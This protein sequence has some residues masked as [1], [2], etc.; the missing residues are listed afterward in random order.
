[1]SDAS[2]S[3]GLVVLPITAGPLIFT[4]ETLPTLNF[5]SGSLVS[6][7]TG[8]EQTQKLPVSGSLGKGV[9]DSDHRNHCLRMSTLGLPAAL[10]IHHS[11][12][13]SYAS[14]LLSAFPTSR[15]W[16]LLRP[17]TALS[18]GSSSQFT[19]FHRRNKR[20]TV[21]CSCWPTLFYSPRQVQIMRSNDANQIH[22]GLSDTISHCI[23]HTLLHR[24]AP[25]MSSCELFNHR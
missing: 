18:R 24:C 9:R 8:G 6:F 22:C 7:P 20:G 3:L 21:Q 15:R 23:H 19:A 10:C 4:C 1:M 12:I 11:L 13:C 25:L 5:P 2:I 14:P 16:R 17:G